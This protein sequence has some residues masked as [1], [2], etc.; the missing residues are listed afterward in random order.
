MK[1]LRNPIGHLQGKLTLSYALTSVL[2]FMLVEVIIII[3]LILLANFQSTSFVRNYLKQQA[4][5]GTPYFVHARPDSLALTAWL[6]IINADVVNQEL[7]KNDRPLFLAVVDTHGLVVTSLGSQ[8]I[9]AAMPL[10]SRLSSTTQATLFIVLRHGREQGSQVEQEPDGN[11][12]GIAPIISERGQVQGALVMKITQHSKIQLYSDLSRA[13]LWSVLLATTIALI[14]GLVFGSLIARGMTRRM[15]TLTAASDRW[16]RGDFSARALDSSR[17]E[18]GQMAQQ[19]NTMAE[20]VQHLLQTRQKLA[21][22]EE[23]NR[24]ARDLHD[25]IKQQMFVVSMQMGAIRVLLRRD[26]DAA[27][28]R[29]LETEKLV[30]EAQ[31]ELTSLIREL[32]P[33]ALE[34]KGL[35]VALR[36]LVTQWSQQTS[37]VANLRVEGAQTLPLAVE[38]ALFRIVQEAL[39]NVARHSQASLVQ[40]DLF[41][42]EDEVMLQITDNGQ[43]FESTQREGAGGVGMHSMQEQ[44]KALKGEIQVESSP[45][46]GTHISIRCRRLAQNP[47]AVS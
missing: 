42:T 28:Q 22:L 23:R 9:P 13:I 41:L 12:V 14:A 3:A 40:I 24:L 29:L 7:L 25:S 36:E 39:S 37:I 38:D 32:R 6:H 15:H 16:S 27:E 44:V 45:G 17:D 20:Q 30:K 4:L 34:G 11:L 5:L 2:T 18:L 46:Q 19:F 26:I 33:T 31:Q 10:Q 8:A 1:R 47:S 43:G 21:T 35:I